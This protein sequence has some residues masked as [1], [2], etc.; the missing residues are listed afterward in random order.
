MKHGGGLFFCYA[1]FE[2]FSSEKTVEIAISLPHGYLKG[3]V[4]VVLVI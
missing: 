2:F 4:P 3:I 1:I